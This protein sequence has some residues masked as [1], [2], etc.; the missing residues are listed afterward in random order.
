M[1]LIYSI[2]VTP[3]MEYVFELVF[4]ELLGISVRFTTDEEKFRDFNGAKINYG[5]Q[6]QENEL[7]CYAENILFEKKVK[8]QN[9]DIGEYKKINCIFYHN[10]KDAFLPFDLFAATFYLVT[11]YEEYLPF[12][13]D[14][15]GRFSH[16]ESIAYKYKFLTRP[17]VNIWVSWLSVV[18]KEK[19]P[20]LKIEKQRFK[21]MPSYDIDIAYAYQNKGLIR[22]L[23]AYLLELRAF[24]FKRIYQRT[25]VLLRKIKDP[26]DTYDYQIALQKKYELTPIYFF[27]LGRFSAY[28]R[29]ISSDTPAYQNLMQSLADYAR[30][31]VHPSYKSYLNKE[32]VKKEIR[33]LSKIVKR[34]IKA[35]RQHYILLDF[36]NIYQTLLKNGI[37][38]EYSMGYPSHIGFR[39]SIASSY[40]FYDLT[41][42]IKTPMRIYPFCIMDVSLKEYMQL[43]TQKALKS[44]L[45]MLEE[46]RRLGGFFMTIFHNHTLSETDGWENWTNFYEQLIAKATKPIKTEK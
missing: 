13:A 28:D 6:K 27:L 18:L 19:F 7:F 39:A 42:E 36:P 33:L 4:S 10:H 14:K 35:S 3:R 8:E 12:K 31:G 40:L 20:N 1:I 11:R 38:K 16:E 29:N 21:F 41:T 32:L 23:G 22:N 25:K 2:S 46:V 26:Y 17:V 15:F 43:D 34:E 9:F 45:E 37:R 24:K 5:K 30:V 44:C